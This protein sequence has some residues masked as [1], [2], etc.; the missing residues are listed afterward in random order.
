[1]VNSTCFSDKVLKTQHFGSSKQTLYL[2]YYTINRSE[3]LRCVIDNDSWILHKYNYFSLLAALS[4]NLVNLSKHVILF[5]PLN[6]LILSLYKEY[7]EH[8][9]VIFSN[10]DHQCL[11]LFSGEIYAKYWRSFC[12]KTKFF[13]NIGINYA[14]KIYMNF[15]PWASTVRLFCVRIVVS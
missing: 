6:I 13:A 2:M 7:R 9:T 12:Q 8:T 10:R 1:M 4:Q 5:K 15:G 14:Q 3:K 11:K